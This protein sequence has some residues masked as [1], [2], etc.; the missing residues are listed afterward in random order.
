MKQHTQECRWEKT[1]EEECAYKATHYFCPH[2]GHHGEPDHSCNCE[3]VAYDVRQH[4]GYS[5]KEYQLQEKLMGDAL[6]GMDEQKA[7]F[8][9]H[10]AS[11]LATEI[12]K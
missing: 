6:K 3:G 9:A 7:I 12:Y 11:T 4:P 2:D 10:V 5:E 8:I 1:T